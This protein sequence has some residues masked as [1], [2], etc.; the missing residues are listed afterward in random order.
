MVMQS[1]EKKVNGKTLS[2]LALVIIILSQFVMAQPQE[3]G[4]EE[5]G[6]KQ[7]Q[8]EPYSSAQGDVISSYIPILPD[9]GKFIWE[10][11]PKKQNEKLSKELKKTSDHIYLEPSYSGLNGLMK[12]LYV[13][14]DVSDTQHFRKLWFKPKADLKFRGL[15]GIHDFKTPRPLIILRMGIHGNVDELIAERFLVK[16]IYDDLDANILILESLTSHAFLSHNKNIS[17]G[18]IDEGLQT[19]IAIKEIEKSYL[20]KLIKTTHLLAISMGAHGTFVTAM[21]DQMNGQ[22]IKSVVDFC[23]L[24]NLESTLERGMESNFKNAAVSIWNVRRLRAVFEHY[25]ENKKIQEWWKA[26]FDFKPHFTMGLMEILGSERRHPLISP[27]EMESLIPKMKW[28]KGFKEHLEN[29]KSF[30]DMNNY[31]SYYQGVKTPI[32]IYTTPND[33]LVINEINSEK[34]FSGEQPGDFTSL[35]YQRLERGVHCGL[36]SVYQWDYI[37]NLVKNGLDLK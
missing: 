26:L 12:A 17:F 19:Y 1:Q 36:P 2:L 3:L 30:Y 21:L 25:P 8:I 15:L 23:P 31:W 22:K 18:G 20:Q 10:W 7:M 9:L 5:L 34:I 29:S 13:E 27:T 32:M 35:K 24:I 6:S 37:V 14:F 11:D 4:W 28:P 16:A 33:P